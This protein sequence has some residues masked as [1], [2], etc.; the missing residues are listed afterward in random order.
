VFH[1]GGNSEENKENGDAQSELSE[2]LAQ[3]DAPIVFT[4]GS[5]AVHH[6]GNFYEASITAAT[7]LN[8]RAILVGFDS[9]GASSRDILSLTYVPFSQAF[10]QAAVIVHQGGSGTIGQALRAGRPMV[11]VPYGW[12]QPDNAA[13]MEKLGV[14]L[15]IARKDYNRETATAALRRVL[16]EASFAI[17]AREVAAALATEDGLTA[18][19]DAI[20]S[21]LQ[22]H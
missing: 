15:A 5:S 16:T 10:E 20:E 7:S 1:D 21:T 8:R 12:D 9:R 4:L 17:R 13:R 18:A 14:G 11:I 22:K 3:G 19:C 6:P 2:F